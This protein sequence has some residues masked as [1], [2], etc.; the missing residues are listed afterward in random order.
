MAVIVVGDIKV[1]D[2]EGLI[3]QNFSAMTRAHR[4]A[5]RGADSP[6]TRRRAYVSVSDP[7]QTASSVSMMMKRPLEPLE[8]AGAV[9]GGVCS[10]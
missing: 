2:I 1:A 5:R 3:R 4:R 9:P 7:E 8:T 6:T 10:G